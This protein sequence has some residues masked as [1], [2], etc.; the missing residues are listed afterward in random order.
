MQP[1]YLLAHSSFS[2]IENCFFFHSEMGK[3]KCIPKVIFSLATTESIKLH[4]LF[5]SQNKNMPF[6]ALDFIFWTLI[7]YIIQLKL[8]KTLISF[9]AHNWKCKKIWAFLFASKKIEVFVNICTNTHG[10]SRKVEPHPCKWDIWI[11]W[12][13]NAIRLC[14]HSSIDIIYLQKCSAMQTLLNLLLYSCTL[15]L[16]S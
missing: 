5:F 8:T 2:S 11:F 15:C 16:K 12:V 13:L 3:L 1:L 14:T 9:G 7:Y 4:E 10:Q 6:S